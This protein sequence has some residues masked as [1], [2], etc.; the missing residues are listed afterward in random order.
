MNQRLKVHLALFSVAV[1]YGS[2]YS[3]AKGLMPQLIGPSGFILLRISVA[4]LLFQIVQRFYV[5]EKVRNRTDLLQLAIAAFFGVAMNMLFFFNGLS[6]TNELN[7]SVLMLN[8][9][10][11]VLIFSALVLKTKIR[12]TQIAGVAIAGIGALLLIGGTGFNFSSKTAAGD[13][14]VVVNATSFA[15]YLVYV[16]RLLN[17]YSVLTITSYIFLFG[18]LYVLPFGLPQLLHARFEDFDGMNWAGL[19]FVC[20]GTTFFAYFLNAWAV[21]KANPV[22]VGTYIY[23]QPLLATLIAQWLGRDVLSPERV[24]FALLICLGVYLTGKRIKP[25]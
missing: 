15:F 1:I 19:A 8:A 18:V 7:A 25:E 24:I 10:V 14:M 5:R 11:F 20:I 17:K 12:K 21:Q 13:L 3:I 22:L 6:R 16:K 4:A 9:P 2:T 23:L